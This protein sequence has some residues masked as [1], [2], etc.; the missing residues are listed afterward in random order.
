MSLNFQNENFKNQNFIETAK[1]ETPKKERQVFGK[2]DL[3]HKG[4]DIK[5]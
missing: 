2:T 4:E 5:T 3:V 1:E